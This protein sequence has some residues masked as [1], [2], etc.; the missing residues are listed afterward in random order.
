M[1]P[2]HWMMHDAGSSSSTRMFGS[3]HKPFF[4]AS[5]WVCK[6]STDM[7]VLTPFPSTAPEDEAAGTA[8]AAVPLLAPT[9]GANSACGKP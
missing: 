4:Q 1:N 9:S 8:E 3:L 7:L 5:T 2:L 6:A